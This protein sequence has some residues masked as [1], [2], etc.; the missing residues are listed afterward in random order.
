[1]NKILALFFAAVLIAG[2]TTQS[3][4]S[5]VDLSGLEDLG[6]LP[7][8]NSSGMPELESLPSTNISIDLDTAMPSENPF[9]SMPT[10][11]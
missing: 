8:I 1:M 4:G 3:S 11:E 10:I 5:N 7:E 2:C 6:E 9:P